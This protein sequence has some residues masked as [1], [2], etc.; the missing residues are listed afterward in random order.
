MMGSRAV[1]GK[2]FQGEQVSKFTVSGSHHK[3]AG[4][5]GDPGQCRSQAQQ[6]GL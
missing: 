4:L 3:L 6:N 2:V 1:D 5:F